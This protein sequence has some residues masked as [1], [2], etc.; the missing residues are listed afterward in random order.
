MRVWDNA[1]RFDRKQASGWGWMVAITRNMAIDRMRSRTASARKKE[2]S[3]DGTGIAE[4]VADSGDNPS[5][6]AERSETATTVTGALETLGDDHRQVIDLSYYEGLSHSKIADRIGAPLGTVK[7]RI[8]SA[9][10]QL[11]GILGSQ[12]EL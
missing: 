3:I 1:S 2:R 11:R 4:T 8:R 7:T 9:I 6:A 10:D 12:N 5:V